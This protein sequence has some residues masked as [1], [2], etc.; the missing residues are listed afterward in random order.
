MES[1]VGKDEKEWNAGFAME[2]GILQKRQLVDL[3]RKYVAKILLHN[4]NEA[5]SFV[6]TDMKNYLELPFDE[7]KR[8][9]KSAHS[10]IDER[11]KMLGL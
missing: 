11:L 10:R 4:I 8:F 9:Q 6:L 1:Y 5:K 7:K 2:K 3:R